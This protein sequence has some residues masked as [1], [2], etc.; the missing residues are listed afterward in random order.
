MMRRLA[1][2]FLLCVLGA[3]MA[4]WITKQGYPFVLASAE[5]RASLEVSAEQLAELKAARY[6]SDAIA[7]GVVGAILVEICMLTFRIFHWIR[8]TDKRSWFSD[9]PVLVVG[10][11]VGFLAGAAGGWLGNSFEDGN[12]WNLDTTTRIM[13]RS[14]IVMLPAAVAGAVGILMIERSARRSGDALLG[15]ILGVGLSLVVTAALHGNLTTFE[16]RPPVFPDQPAN[17]ALFPTAYLF[18]TTFLICIMA[19]RSEAG[20]NE[21]GREEANRQG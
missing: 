5:A 7:Y 21:S 17:R 9:L 18:C 8:P 13:I 16:A 19:G 6:A 10:A 15:A 3:A 4:W 2:W 14:A 11:G 20:R 1:S 12:S